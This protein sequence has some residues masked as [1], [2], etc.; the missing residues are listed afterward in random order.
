MKEEEMKREELKAKVISI[1]WVY[2]LLK[3]EKVGSKERAKERARSY[4]RTAKVSSHE[5]KNRGSKINEHIIS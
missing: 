5:E 3:T 4:S 2:P 1:T